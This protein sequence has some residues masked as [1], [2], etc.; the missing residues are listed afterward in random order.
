MAVGD[1]PYIKKF[2][3]DGIVPDLNG[4]VQKGIRVSSGKHNRLV[5]NGK[6]LK[7]PAVLVYSS[8]QIKFVLNAAT[9]SVGL[10]QRKRP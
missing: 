4:S 10:E 8:V 2:W 3:Y 1:A 6:Y 9:T 7:P 5:H